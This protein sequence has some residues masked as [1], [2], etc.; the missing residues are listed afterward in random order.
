MGNLGRRVIVAVIGIPV[1]FGFV[2]SGELVLALFLATLGALGAGE[3]YRLARARD[4]QPFDVIGA[5]LAAGFPVGAHL[6]RTGVIDRP[7]SAMGV[8]FVVV[9]GLAVW[10]RA[11]DERPLEAVAITVFG[12][13]YCGG[14]LSFGYALRH[15]P[16]VIGAVAGTALVLYPVVITWSTDIAAYFVGRGLGKRK[17]I[18]AVSPGKTVAGAVGGF[19]AAV[20]VAVVYNRTV[21]RPMAHLALAPGT[22]LGLGAILS[23]VAQVGDLAKSLF[24]REAGV[25]DSSNLLPGHGGILDRLDSLYFVL[26]VAYLLLGRLLLPA[27]A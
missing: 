24:K 7:M 10:G 13:I 9:A 8:L 4:G 11:P 25:K 27:P 2:Y 19:A 16:W 17:L 20:V 6:V 21:L 3:L 14:T 22:A 18:P 1:A 5:A 12:A 15:H 26:P 23:V